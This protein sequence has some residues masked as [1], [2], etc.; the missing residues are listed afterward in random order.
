MSREDELRNSLALCLMLQALLLPGLAVGQA[1]PVLEL[2]TRIALESVR[3]RMDHMGVD[4]MGQRLFAAAF[5]NRTLEVIDLQAGKQVHTIANLN[6]PQAA[7][8]DPPTNRLF[9]A[10]GGDGT[11]KI[12][13]GRTLQLVQTVQLSSDADNVR[14][15]SRSSRVV[16]GY[17]GEKSLYGQVARAQGQKDGAL[18]LIDPATGQKTGQI[19][20]DAHPESFQ[21]EKSGTSVFINVPDKKEILVADLASTSVLAQWP[22]PGCT[23]NFPMALDEAHHRLFVACRSP[24][25]LIAFDM[26]SGKPAASILFTSTIFSDD[27]F[28]DVSKSRVYVIAR[29]AQKDNPRAPGPGVVVVVQQKD[30]DHYEEIGSYPTGF[31]AQTGYFV[32]EWGKLYVAT[33]RQPGGQNSEILVFETK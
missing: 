2:K 8:Y 6:Q 9:V 15:D 31:G 17:G 3:G 18:A 5:D 32:P 27:I 22:V 19:A 10:S 20:T 28:Y 25:S 13:D 33:R 26:E 12:F 23:D 11:V 16:V 24:A 29:V 21:L 4:L 7:Y 1:S 30:P 14:Y